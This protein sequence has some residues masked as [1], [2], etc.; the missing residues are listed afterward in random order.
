MI[1]VLPYRVKD[2]NRNISMFCG[3]PDRDTV[4]SEEDIINL[5]IA[6]NI[7]CP[8]GFDNL[9]FFLMQV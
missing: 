9:Y 7:S 8:A 3:R 5:K 6:L 1:N 2:I 4:I